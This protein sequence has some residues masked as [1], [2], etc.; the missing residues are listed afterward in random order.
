MSRTP[1]REALRRLTFEGWVQNSFKRHVMEVK[2]VSEDDVEELFEIRELFELR[3]IERIFAAKAC[4]QVGSV[5]QSLADCLKVSGTS[6]EFDDV[7]YM[8][9]DMR[10]HTE[11]MYFVSCSR[12]YRF[13]MQINPEFIRL[14]SMTLKSPRGARGTVY[15]E[16]LAIVRGLL[17]HRKKDVREAVH[18][19]NERTKE[20]I[21]QTLDGLLL[22]TGMIHAVS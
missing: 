13:W 11:V 15:E 14:G 5:L 20:Y 21:F 22:R 2:P 1:V 8:S 4:I 16:H 18:Y 9:M 7:A 17:S 3:G 12:L 10:L 19:H 6:P